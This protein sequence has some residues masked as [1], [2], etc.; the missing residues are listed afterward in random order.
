MAAPATLTNTIQNVNDIVLSWPASQYAQTYNIYMISADDQKTLLTSVTSRTYTISNTAE[1]THNYAVSAVNSL[2]GE[3]PIS[4]LLQVNV[5]FPTMT[6]PSNVSYKIQ[7][8]NDV[9]LTWKA[10]TYADSYKIYEIVDGQE[11]LK[12]SVTSLSAT[13]SNVLAG[14]HTYIIHSASTRFGESTEGSQVPLT[15]DAQTMQAPANLTYSMTNGTDITLKWGA[16]TY[17][18]AYNVYQLIDGEKILKSTVNGTSVS[19]NNL[20]V[21]SYVYEVH[22]NSDRFGES[23]EG[24]QVSI[25]LGSVIMAPP[26]NFAYTINNGNDIVLNWDSIPNVTNYKIYQITNGQKLLKSTVTG[27][28]VSY[29]S[30]PAS[31][32][33]YEYHSYST[34]YGESVEGSKLVFN[35]TFPSMQPPANLIQAIKNATDF[36]LSWDASSY[37]NSYKVYQLVNGKKVLKN[38]VTATTVAL[39]T[40]M[41]PGEYS[42]EVHSYSTKFGESPEGSTLVVTLNGQTMQAPTDL[43]YT[44]ANQ[45]DITLKWTAA[46]YATSYNIYQVIDGQNVLKKTVTSTSLTFANMPAGDYHYVVTSVSTLFGESPSGAEVTLSLV[47]PI[48]AVQATSHTRFKM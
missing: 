46:T 10:V 8:G 27:T 28:T 36:S 29:T 3:S 25:G 18:T 14:N 13:L 15:V 47:L 41:S 32:Y 39:S 26:S 48:M 9:V 20:P 35:L 6:V 5:V 40:N 19:F 16:V 38:T 7:N 11:Y 30:M 23:P 12:T 43:T 42:F 22:S 44:L 45:N 21:G 4:N 24:S 31:D 34:S 1:G 2:Y 17:A 37:A 33:S